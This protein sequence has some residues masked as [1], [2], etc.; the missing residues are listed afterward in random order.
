M[1][2]EKI[3]EVEKCAQ[4]Q[5]EEKSLQLDNVMEKLERHN[6]RKEKLKQQL[7]SKEVELEEIR[8]AY[9]YSI[10]LSTG[11][12]KNVACQVWW[13]MFVIPDFGE[14]ETFDC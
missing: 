8:K 2:Q 11:G 9:R 13:H 12:E 14:A 10:L 6:E 5:L 7:K 4:Q 3:T 1:L